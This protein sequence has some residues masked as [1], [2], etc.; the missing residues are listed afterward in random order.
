MNKS[1]GPFCKSCLRLNYYSENFCYWRIWRTERTLRARC[2][3]K[4]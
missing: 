2:N 3:G 4:I 1:P